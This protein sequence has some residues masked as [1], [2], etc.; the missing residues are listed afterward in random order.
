MTDE[1]GP[2]LWG[3]QDNHAAGIF[4]NIGVTKSGPLDL[5]LKEIASLCPEAI[6][7]NHSAYYFGMILDKI[8][9]RSMFQSK[10]T[11][12]LVYIQVS[13]W[14]HVKKIEDFL[15]PG[16][17]T[18]LSFWEVRLIQFFVQISDFSY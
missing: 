1:V 18:Y 11:I 14:V 6:I 17:F 10:Y 16:E 3:C 8:C 15:S 9:L 2:T 13:D 7:S 12:S 5:L 4:K